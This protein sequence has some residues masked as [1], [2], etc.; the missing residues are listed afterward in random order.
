MIWTSISAKFLVFKIRRVSWV[1]IKLICYVFSLPPQEKSN[2][3]IGLEKKR[4]SKSVIAQK[5]KN[6]FSKTNAGVFQICVQR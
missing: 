6:S 3:C 2:L 1:Y 4:K 5:N